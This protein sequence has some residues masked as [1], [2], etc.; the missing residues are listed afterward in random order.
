M[1]RRYGWKQVHA[2]GQ[3]RGGFVWPLVAAAEVSSCDRLNPANRGVCPSQPG[4]GLSVGL[5]ARGMASAGIRSQTVL[6]VSWDDAD[7]AA[8]D[9]DKVR[10]SGPVRVEMVLDRN[11]VLRDHGRG[12]DLRGADLGGAYL[13]GADLR[14][15]ERGPGG[16]ARKIAL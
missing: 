4:D 1:T 12:A 3:T 13:R 7:T 10:V 9:A 14:G 16:Y 15:W 2:D 6:I 5:T 8:E 11:R